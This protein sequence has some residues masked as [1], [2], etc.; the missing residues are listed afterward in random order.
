VWSR[1]SQR[2]G[3]DAVGDLAHLRSLAHRRPL[4]EGERVIEFPKPP[5]LD[6]VGHLPL[7]PYLGRNDEISDR[8]RYQTVYASHPGSIAAPT[9]GLHFTDQLL[10]ELDD[11]GI[12]RTFITLHVGLGTFKPISAD[13][14]DCEGA[15]LR[16]LVRCP[17]HLNSDVGQAGSLRA[18]VNRAEAD[19][20]SAAACQAAPQNSYEI[21]G[22]LY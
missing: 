14:G 20:Q 5:D 2:A 16:T 9:A 3:D 6:A 19:C 21:A 13:R 7:P 8:E 4:D 12:Q 10:K 17:G 11:A 1:R 18:V 22:T 15:V